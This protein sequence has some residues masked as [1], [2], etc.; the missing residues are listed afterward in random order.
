MSTIVLHSTLNISETVIEIEARF[1]RTTNRKWFMGYSNGHV[2]DDVTWP[3]KVKLVTS[4]RAQYLKNGWIK[5]LRSKGPPIGNGIWGLSNGHVTNDV[6]W[7]QSCCDAVQSAILAT[8]G[9]LCVVVGCWLQLW[10]FVNISQLI[11]WE[12]LMWTE[13]CLQSGQYYIIPR[14]VEPL[15]LLSL[16]TGLLSFRVQTYYVCLDADSFSLHK[17]SVG[18]R[19]E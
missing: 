17:S 2:T 16:L 8:A 14:D 7:P 12:N 19:C 18:S 10:F 4:L 9:L 3:W 11:G 6:T 15:L 13:D 5:R 1:Q